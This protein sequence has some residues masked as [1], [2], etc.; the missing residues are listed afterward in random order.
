MV[1]ISSGIWADMF[2]MELVPVSHKS[3][4]SYMENMQVIVTTNRDYCPNPYST[5]Y[6]LCKCVFQQCWIWCI[7][8]VSSLQFPRPFSS[9]KLDSFINNIEVHAVCVFF[10]SSY[11]GTSLPSFQWDTRS[12]LSSLDQDCEEFALI[13]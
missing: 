4:S 1:I 9:V 5:F 10:C 3:Q 6:N 12:C 13:I 7:W 2:I 8:C 11:T